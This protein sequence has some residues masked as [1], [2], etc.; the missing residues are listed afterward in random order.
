VREQREG[1]EG[2]DVRHHHVSNLMNSS[3][4]QEKEIVGMGIE[5]D[6]QPVVTYEKVSQEEKSRIST[7]KQ[8][9]WE[10]AGIGGHEK[11]CKDLSLADDQHKT[12]LH[13]QETDRKGQT[14]HDLG[15]S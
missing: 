3:W 7:Q 2:G 5:S 12:K 9:H 15:K 10:A 1:G 14:L 8:C 6:C 11:W 13:T 4:A